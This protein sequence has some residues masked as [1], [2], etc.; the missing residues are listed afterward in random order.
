MVSKRKLRSWFKVVFII[1]V[2]VLWVDL[3]GYG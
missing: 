2:F 1:M 3:G